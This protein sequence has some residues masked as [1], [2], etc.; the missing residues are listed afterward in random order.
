[1]QILVS[2]VKHAFSN[3]ISVL[4][5]IRAGSTSQKR[6]RLRRK[7]ARRR[8]SDYSTAV[9]VNESLQRYRTE[10]NF[11]VSEIELQISCDL[12]GNY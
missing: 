8:A 3:L 2:R 12:L 11:D 7:S 6:L 10:G 9:N 5:C 4:R 1:M